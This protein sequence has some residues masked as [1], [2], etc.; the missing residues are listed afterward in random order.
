[1]ASLLFKHISGDIQWQGIKISGSISQCSENF[2]EDLL[3]FPSA[4]CPRC[5]LA[6]F[7]A[8]GIRGISDQNFKADETGPTAALH[9]KRFLEWPKTHIGYFEKASFMACKTMQKDYRNSSSSSSFLWHHC[10]IKLEPVTRKPTSIRWEVGQRV[11]FV[12]LAE[13]PRLSS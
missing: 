11:Q 13:L 6:W 3:P 5:C 12:F 2:L 1:M 7:N 4:V 8:W 10:R 9:L